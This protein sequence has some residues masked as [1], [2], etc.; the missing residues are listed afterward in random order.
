M[1]QIRFLVF[2]LCLNW[3]LSLFISVDDGQ[4]QEMAV[5]QAVVVQDTFEPRSLAVDYTNTI[6]YNGANYV[7]RPPTCCTQCKHSWTCGFCPS[8][9]F[10]AAGG[11]FIDF[12]SPCILC[13]PWR[14]IE[15]GSMIAKISRPYCC[16]NGCCYF[17]CWCFVCKEVMTAKFVDE[18]GSWVATM[19]V[20]DTC[21]RKCC[22]NP[23]VQVLCEAPCTQC[24]DD[25][26]YC[27]CGKSKPPP[28]SPSPS[29]YP[30]V[31]A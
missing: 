15:N 1:L 4:V 25:C 21:C 10:V 19:R 27:C 24:I 30:L 7:Q 13:Y 3:I 8:I 16:D 22:V 5:I 20:N 29:P 9:G 6:M 26:S 18:S 31:H 11:K 23:A 2:Q 17:C 28:P 12:M 14:A